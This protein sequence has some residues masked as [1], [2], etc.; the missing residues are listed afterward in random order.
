MD[1]APPKGVCYMSLSLVRLGHRQARVRGSVRLPFAARGGYRLLLA[2]VLGVRGR[3]EREKGSRARGI[4][5]G[6]LKIGRCASCPSVAVGVSVAGWRWLSMAMRNRSRGSGEG[7]VLR[8]P[9]ERMRRGRAMCAIARD[10]M[11]RG[12]GVEPY[13][14]RPER[15]SRRE[16]KGVWGTRAPVCG[17]GGSCAG[18]P[19]RAKKGRR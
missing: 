10:S 3:G 15:R 13:T 7:A 9:C 5:I 4:E 14:A 2:E 16:A 17:G 8:K 18:R 11:R 12:E 6:E 1:I 19:P